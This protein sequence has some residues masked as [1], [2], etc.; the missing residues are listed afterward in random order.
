M[1][2]LGPDLV[3]MRRAEEIR[4]KCASAE[5]PEKPAQL[6][7]MIPAPAAG[8]WTL[9]EA[10]DLLKT[11]RRL[12]LQG[13]R[14][15]DYLSNLSCT[16]YQ[17]C[18]E[19][20]YHLDSTR[21]RGPMT[22]LKV[23]T[24]KADPVVPSLMSLFPGA[25]LQER[26]VWD[27]FGVRFDGHPNLKRILMWEGF[28]GHP[29]RKDYL[30][31]YYEA[32]GKIFP[33]RW[34][35]GHHQ[36]AEERTPF[37]DNVKYPAGFDPTRWSAPREEFRPVTSRSLEQL[38]TDTL[39]INLGP[40]HPS[41]HGVFRMQVRVDGER[42]VALEPV[43]GYMH[44]NH[45]KIA[46][47]NTWLMVFPYT[48]RLDY[49]CSMGNNLGY[50]IA[51]EKLQGVKPPERAEYIRVIMAELTRVVNHFWATG[52]LLNDLGAFFTP[53]NCSTAPA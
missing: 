26:E 34:K 42:I 8:N 37:S 49:I 38:K 50:A 53:V 19:V 15:M 27:L 5:K 9:V 7:A 44:R 14:P 28:E 16:D 13:D 11:V 30:E 29:M 32:P 47:R 48:D 17:D 21:K 45:E 40:Q 18:Y 35:E 4:E 46:E 39:V 36:R 51:V 52:F 41:T 24:P 1:P 3:D 43:M 12:Q 31:P 23:R 10:G 33:S 2:L 25:D 20:V 6:P 22:T